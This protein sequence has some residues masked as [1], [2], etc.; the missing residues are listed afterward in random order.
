M[1]DQQK[2]IPSEKRKAE[3]I[4]QAMRLIIDFDGSQLREIRRFV[5]TLLEIRQRQGRGDEEW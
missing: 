2:T 4:S 5:D 1:S 3:A